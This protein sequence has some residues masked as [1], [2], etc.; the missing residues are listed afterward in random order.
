[1][2]KTIELIVKTKCKDSSIKSIGTNIFEARLTN[3]PINGR[4]NKELLE[5]LS[6][7]FKT[8]KSSIEIISGVKSKHKLIEL[9]S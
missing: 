2:S 7:Y 8:P 6:K 9:K 1:M 3:A 4:A 5:L